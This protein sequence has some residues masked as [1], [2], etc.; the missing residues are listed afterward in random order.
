MPELPE[1]EATRRGLDPSV[2]G[3]RVTAVRV[4]E[5]RLRWPVPERL[6]RELPGT[7]LAGAERRAKYLLLPAGPGTVLVHLGMS[8]SLRRLPDDTPIGPHDHVDLAL[9]DGHLLRLRDPRRFGAVMWVTG[10]PSLDPRLAHL[11]P[12][13]LSEA[14][15]GAYLHAVSRGRRARVKSLLMDGTVVVGVGNIYAS[16]ALFAAGVHPH[17]AAGRVGR[18]RCDRLAAAVKEVL[19]AAIEHGGTT[20]RDYAGID[21]RPGG[22]AVRLAVYGRSGE[23]C[24][25]CGASVRLTRRDARATYHCPGCQR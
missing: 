1:V 11:G 12:E 5:R 4:R 23:P 22:N 19:A 9:D 25:R 24:L 16:E 13:P 3:R 17:R 6:E 8:G 7:V 15:D 2:R 18:E 21:G 14:F 20:L 10:D